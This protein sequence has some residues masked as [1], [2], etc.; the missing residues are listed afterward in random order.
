MAYKTGNPGLNA[1]TFERLP[2]PA[3][4]SDRMT[5][6]GAVNKSFAL[7][8]ILLVTA[9]WAW[10]RFFETRDSGFASRI[11]LFGAVGGFV[12]GLIVVYRKTLA[13]YLAP[14]YAGFEGVALG[15]ISAIFEQRYPGIAIQAVGLTFGVLAA[16]LIAYS[17]RLIR[18]SENFKL[19]VVSATG[20]I[21]ILYLLSLDLG[22][23]GINVQYIY[24]SGPIGILF[25]LFVVIVAATNLVLD[26]DFIES[27]VKRGVP[28]Y[29]EW[30]AAFGLLVTLVWLYLEILR[31]LGKSRRR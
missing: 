6:Q 30:Y 28:K 11:A 17:S 18:P 9:A 5:L 20:G 19:G 31:L 13:P 27:G 29:M 2:I 15:G 7:L 16:L 22:F 26:F 21:A 12:V 8:F 10:S 25:S 23:F 14:V 24:D 3:V 4:S 1:K